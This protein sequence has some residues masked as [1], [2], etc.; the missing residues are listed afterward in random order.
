MLEKIIS[1]DKELLVFLN[2]LGATQY[3]G[4]WLLITK[5]TNWILFFLLLLYFIGKK[6]GAKQTLILLLFVA[7]LV[8]I[9]DQ[10]TNLFKY[11]FQRLRPCSDPSINTMI[12]VV[13]SS[14]TFS[15]FS[16]H[17][18]SSMAVSMFIFLN[19]SKF[20]KYTFLLFIWPLFFAY[21]RIY[22]GLHFPIDIITG[23]IFGASLGFLMYK[24]Y[25]SLRVKYFST[26][27]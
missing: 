22:L 7:L 2:N 24:L 13:K 23:Y 4:F 19:I 12:R 17:A 1:L 15:F 25:Q 14:A 9:S 3:D 18:A 20:Y 10:T 5:Q 16:G 27:I 21:S 11:G 26:I 6:F 8:T